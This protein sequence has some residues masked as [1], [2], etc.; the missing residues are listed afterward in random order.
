M[1]R[2]GDALVHRALAEPGRFDVLLVDY[3][4]P[5]R[6]G[7]RAIEAVRTAGVETPALMI[8]GNVDFR[9]RA[10]AL[11]NTDFLQKPFG[12]SEIRDWATHHLAQRG[13]DAS[14]ES[15]P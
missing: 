8:S 5:G 11:S 6:D 12:L 2:N 3:D 14:R 15:T 7:A 13:S 4:L 10:D 1:G 9:P